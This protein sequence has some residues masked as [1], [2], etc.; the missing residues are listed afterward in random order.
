MKIMKYRLLFLTFGLL[1]SVNIP[2]QE[3]INIY[4]DQKGADIQPSMYGI[5][6]EEI[7]RSGDGGLYAELVQNRSFEDVEMYPGWHVEGGKLY[8]RPVVHHFTHETDK[9]AFAWPKTDLPGWSLK[10]S[11]PGSANIHLTKERPKFN[12]APN[13]L[14]LTITKPANPVSLVNSGFMGMSIIKGERYRLRMIIRKS[15]E[16][17]GGIVVRLLS[18]DNRVITSKRIDI[19]RDGWQDIAAVLK[20]GSTDAGAKLALEFEGKGTVWLD[21]VSLF[22]ERTFR[23]RKNGFRPDLAQ[24]LA[25]LKPAFVRWPGGSIVGG[26]TLDN[27]FDWKK[28][29]GDPAA[30]SGEYITWGYRCSYGMGYYETLQFCEDIGADAMYVCNVGLSDLFRSGEACPEDS[31]QYFIDDCLDAIEYALGDVNTKWGARRAADGHPEPFPLKYVEIGNEHWGREYDRRVDMFY[32][33]IKARYPQLTL[34]SDHPL[35]GTETATKTDMVDP[36]W[37]GTPEFFFRSSTMFDSV[38]R[39]KYGV[40]VGEWAC[41]FGVG[42]GNM[43]AALAEAAFIGNMER[44]ADL[45]RM[46]S[47]APLLQNRHRRDW[48]VNLIWFDSDRVV[49]RS[50]YYV[51]KMASLNRPTYNV[52]YNYT[53]APRPMEN[54]KG[55]IGFGSSKTPL[56]VKDIK[57]TANGKAFTPDLSKGTSRRGKWSITDGTLK[58]TA[59]TGSSMFVLND[60]ESNDFTLECKARKS[61]QKEGIFLYYGLTDNGQQGFIYNIGGW[62]SSAI[63]VEQLS[64][65][66]NTGSVGNAVTAFIK[67][68]EWY[69]LKLVVTPRGSTLYVDGKRMLGNTPMTTPRQFVATGIDEAKNELVIKVVNSDSTYYTPVLNIKGAD[70]IERKGASITLAADSGLA[71]NS[72]DNPKLIHPEQTVY[73]GFKKSFTYNFK[74]YSYTVL[75]IKLKK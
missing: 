13:N 31:I 5:F 42:K 68:D 71:E 20:A 62:N 24:T 25:D 47:F 32:S 4:A 70:F 74:P 75:R 73:D 28:T 1:L 67:P 18:A 21:Y 27:R 9:R 57:I 11:D 45:V 58:Q 49:P 29:L 19:G 54:M 16:Y 2:A 48:S 34:I 61:A 72:F 37:Y 52:R 69:S 59:R 23:N 12:T 63:S 55:R 26:I 38:P 14:K 41:N 43:R 35:W 40:Y 60:I 30:R 56:E 46:T 51:Q 66:H 22:P 50:S 33:A 64:A 8:S 17:K 44:N 10:V 36:H 7:N 39:G 6:F 3:T 15:D 65:G 53:G